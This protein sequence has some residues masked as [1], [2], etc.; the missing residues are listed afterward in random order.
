MTDISKLESVL[1]GQRRVWRPRALLNDLDGTPMGEEILEHREAIERAYDALD[2][3][4]AAAT[5]FQILTKGNDL[6]DRLLEQEE[7]RLG[8]ASQGESRCDKVGASNS[9]MGRPSPSNS[10]PP[11]QRRRELVEPAR[12]PNASD[13]P[14]EAILRYL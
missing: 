10:H 11:R 4:V 6:L 2:G 1:D 13:C 5:V 8:K 7:L 14:L 9:N 12:V 3:A